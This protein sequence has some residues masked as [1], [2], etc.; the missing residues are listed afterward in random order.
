MTNAEKGE[1][2]YA[3]CGVV[4]VAAVA[5]IQ[6]TRRRSWLD[7]PRVWYRDPGWWAIICAGTVI[8]IIL[9]VARYWR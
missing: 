1:L 6:R 4:V 2:I 7:E 3:M 9:T 8:A 5:V